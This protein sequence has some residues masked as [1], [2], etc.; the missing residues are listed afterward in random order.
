MFDEGCDPIQIFLVARRGPRSRWWE[1]NPTHVQKKPP[2]RNRS[3]DE[4]DGLP[5]VRAMID[6]SARASPP[7][8]FAPRSRI[9][10]IICLAAADSPLY[11][12]ILASRRSD[13]ARLGL[14]LELADVAERRAVYLFD[15][16]LANRHVRI[17]RN[18]EGPE[19][20]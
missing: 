3:P 10:L 13:P 15:N 1:I 4:F 14:P 19:V 5:S 2:A 17:E 12:I 6:Q 18:I 16:E 20:D 8:G 7:R 9:H 11:C